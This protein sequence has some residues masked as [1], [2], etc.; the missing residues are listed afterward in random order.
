M[1]KSSSDSGLSELTTADVGPLAIVRCGTISK[2]V[3]QI[4][5]INNLQRE[6]STVLENVN[7][8]TINSILISFH[9]FFYRWSTVCS[10]YGYSR[11][12]TSAIATLAGIGMYPLVDDEIWN[13]DIP[14]QGNQ[15]QFAV[16]QK[17]LN[18]VTFN[19]RDLFCFSFSPTVYLFIIFTMSQ[20][21][22]YKLVLYAS[23]VLAVGLYLFELFVRCVQTFVFL[24][25]LKNYHGFIKS[26]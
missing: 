12:I 20:P 18:P 8:C 4:L 26:D 7:W 11:T 24:L 22:P 21:C 9:F 15:F 19:K 2:R 17:I 10:K 1:S 25:L 6:R 3:S 13:S 23:L 14:I 5:F 16:C